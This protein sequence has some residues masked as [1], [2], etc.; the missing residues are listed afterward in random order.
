MARDAP[1][2][3]VHLLKRYREGDGEA[4]R[5]LFERHVDLL[6]QRIGRS[7]PNHLRRRLAVSDVLQ[8]TR[9]V[10]F[11]RRADFEVRGEDGFRKWLLGIVEMKIR[12]AIR[13]HD[14]TVKRSAHREVTRGQRLDTG[15]FCGADPSP[16]EVA[17][18]SE[19]VE[20][21]RRALER[22]P[23]DYREVLRLT[24]EEGL[25]LREAAVRMG[26]SPEAVRKLCGRAIC[27]FKE[28]FEEQG[29]G[30]GA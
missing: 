7:L 12:E 1:E 16:S 25:T 6:Q 2:P 15:Q 5:T 21:A 30:G 27:R 22:L 3:D 26:R 9:I 20:R 8:E 4:F 11:E 18:T 28:V 24:R 13:R 10:A 23:D 17:A 29:G 14:R 19:L